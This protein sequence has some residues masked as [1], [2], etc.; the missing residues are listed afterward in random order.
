MRYSTERIEQILKSPEGRT[1]LGYVSPI[2]GNSYVA[3]WLFQ[4]MGLQLDDLREWV[5]ELPNQAF[6]Q[7]ATWGLPYWEDEYEV[8]PASDATI[9][10]RQRDLLA[11]LSERAPVNPEKMARMV[12]A[13]TGRPATIQE[14]TAKRTFFICIDITAGGAPFS[15]D[16]Y[17]KVD[18]MKPAHLIYS[19]ELAIHG[20]ITVGYSQIA[21]KFDAP[22]C[23]TKTC[24][25]YPGISTKG[26]VYTVNVSLELAELFTPFND[27][28]CG[29]LPGISTI[30]AVFSVAV[31][32]TAGSEKAIFSPFLSD[33]I[34]CG[35]EPGRAQVGKLETAETHIEEADQSTVF[36]VPACG[37]E[38]E[39]STE[40]ETE[41][42]TLKCSAGMA[43][44]PTQARVCGPYKCGN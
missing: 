28:I 30:G 5:N 26:A 44:F 31:E 19:W 13:A 40:G 35:N 38:P 9:E 8:S 23:G 24:G 36:D 39:T 14:R 41:S 32:G 29:V 11:K 10:S 15:L 20:K 17:K 2:Y 33:Q 3:L 22:K 18:L 25:T 1:I 21:G 34:L 6:P 16:F 4:V 42:G 27:P 37:T 43:V 7:T 12:S